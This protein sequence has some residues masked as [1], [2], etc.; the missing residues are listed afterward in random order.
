MIAKSTVCGWLAS[1]LLLI[2]A[3]AVAAQTAASGTLLGAISD[4]MG[5]A[6]P[7]VT[8]TATNNETGQTRTTATGPDGSYRI[9]SLVPGT[10]RVKFEGTGFETLEIPSVEVKQMESVVL[11]RSLEVDPA[12]AARPTL[13][14]SLQSNHTAMG[15][16][17]LFELH[18][19]ACHGNSVA[20][21]RAPDL[22]ALMKLT[23][24]EILS[25]LTIGPM[26]TQAQSL[27]DVEKRSIAEFLSGRPPGIGETGDAKLMSNRCPSNPPLTD[28]SAGPTWNGWGVDVA[29][30]RFQNTKGAGISADQ[31]PMLKLKWTF[32]FPN[33]NDSYDQA[34][35]ASGRVFVGSDNG[36]VYSLQATTGC[37]YWS[38]RA[39]SGIRA[40]ISVGP[41]KGNGPA[42]FALYFGDIKANVYALDA[43]SGRLLW[44]THVEDHP[45]ARI[46]GSPKL[47]KNL[48]YVPVSSSEE[49]NSIL[50][51]YPCCTFR[52]SVV[53]LDTATGR[54]VWKTYTISETPAP[55]RKNSLGTQ[56]WAPA[57][58]AIWSSPTVDPK[59][60][61]LYV[62]TGDGYTEP[63]ARNSDSIMAFD[64]NSGRIL[65]S[66]QDTEG[67]AWMSGCDS[68]VSD[69]CPKHLGPDY[70]FGASPILRTLANGHR[71]I[72]AA[73]KSG[74]VLAHDPDHRGTL[75]WKTN[76]GETA[77]SVQGLMVF[78]GAADEQ[79][80]YFPLTTGGAAAVQLSTGE[81]RWSTQFESPGIDSSGKPRPYAQTAAAS[82]IP[83]IVFMGGWD[84]ILRALSTTNG[85]VVWEY[86]MLRQFDTVNGVRGSGGSMGS[87]GPT[88][89]G[90]M[91]FVSSGYFS[92][93]GAGYAGNVLLAF[94]V[95]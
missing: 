78:G 10:Y 25:V 83:G 30:S 40:A 18:C 12:T 61:A 11:N 77:P 74:N 49:G 34:T 95:D 24:E 48:L 8:V 63:A 46:T 37:V 7:S 85:K 89:A 44:K 4:A 51:Q 84:G 42:K 29:N 50:I 28:P 76:L 91:L 72:V 86:N 90:G 27:T 87:G 55:T 14:R 16:L 88:I 38:F 32:G 79:S 65:W 94:G 22:S 47:Y 69:N 53:G 70:D 2:F 1:V 81:R 71:I 68:D 54:Q 23:P 39:A 3:P 93:R 58:A 43:A 57:G 59:R 20:G 35:V 9:G 45:L 26:S 92:N 36:Y 5:T 62:G 82:A 52:G 17:H 75:A 31:V 41:V 60:H 64:L 80:A 67:D 6:A 13:G 21:Q 73:Q 56:L 19:A 15:G 33:G 66:V